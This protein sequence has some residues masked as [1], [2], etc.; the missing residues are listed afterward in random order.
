MSKFDSV[1]GNIPLIARGSIAQKSI[2][3]DAYIKLQVRLSLDWQCRKTKMNELKKRTKV[4]QDV[5]SEA[6]EDNG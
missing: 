5:E 2:I 3:S 4:R 6:G 1:V